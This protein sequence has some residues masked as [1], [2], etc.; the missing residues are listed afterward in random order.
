MN[1]CP[2]PACKG[3]NIASESIGNYHDVHY[4]CMDCHTSGPSVSPNKF[5]Y[6]ND[7]YVECEKRWDALPRF[8]T[9]LNP[10]YDDST[11]FEDVCPDDDTEKIVRIERKKEL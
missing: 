4:V 1:P 2:I 3:A 6:G 11:P 5:G 8:G 9:K 10:A 7:L